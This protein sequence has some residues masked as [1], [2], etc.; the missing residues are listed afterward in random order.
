MIVRIE[1]DCNW[2]LD[3][4][5][6]NQTCHSGEILRFSR[7]SFFPMGILQSTYLSH[8]KD[9][10]EAVHGNIWVWCGWYCPISKPYKTHIWPIDYPIPDPYMVHICPISLSLVRVHVVQWY[11]FAFTTKQFSLSI[12]RQYCVIVESYR[13]IFQAWQCSYNFNMIAHLVKMDQ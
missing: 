5:S 9:N 13:H 3:R 2:L 1:V 7:P 10:R 6:R 8:R 12:A 4:M 11:F